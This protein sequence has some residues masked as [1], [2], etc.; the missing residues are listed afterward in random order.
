MLQKIEDTILT[1]SQIQLYVYR[2][3]LL[4]PQMGGNKY[5]KLKYN[6]LEAQHQG[7]NTLLTFGG[8]YSNHIYATA[9]AGKNFGFKTIGIIR[10]EEH[11]P[12]NET[13]DF[14]QQVGMQLHYIDRNTYRQK[15]ETDF[16]QTLK[17]K[18][19]DFYLLPEGG[20]NGLAVK[21][22][23]EIMQDIAIHWDYVCTPCGTG[24]TLAGLIAGLQP[25]QKA[26]GFSVLKAGHFLYEDVQKNLNE[27]AILEQKE[28]DFS[29]KWQI[30]LD[31]HFGG[32]AK[33]KPELQDFIHRFQ[34]QHQIPLEWIYSGKMMF[35]I[36]DLIQKKYFPPHTIIIALHTG[37]LREW[38]G[39]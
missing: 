34:T 33:N 16:I 21:G 30:Q 28:A 8:A 12:L 13:L 29:K 38:I 9:S 2:L 20:S 31:Y 15:S 25:T 6:L 22:A 24:G 26:L 32:Y 19:G 11:L 1:S 39:K 23:S 35:G 14:A 10:G 17:E 7:F 37:G 5:F 4:H 36:Y 3:D 18:F 27:Y